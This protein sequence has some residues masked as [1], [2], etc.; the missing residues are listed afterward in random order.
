M[1][2]LRDGI[3][4]GAFASSEQPDGSRAPGDPGKPE[5]YE[6]GA[7]AQDG[8]ERCRMVGRLVAAWLAQSEFYPAPADPGIAGVDALSQDAGARAHPRG[9]PS[10]KGAGGS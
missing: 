2:A 4:R 7:R 8:C 10:A 9:E 5:A 3:E 6:G 1:R